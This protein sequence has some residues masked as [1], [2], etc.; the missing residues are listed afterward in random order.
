MR[1]DFPVHPFQ[2]MTEPIRRRIVEVLASGEHSY[3][4]IVEAISIEFSVTDAA[5][6]WH[7]AILLDNG[8]VITRDDYPYRFYRLDDHA[9]RWLRREVRHLEK[10]WRNRYGTPEG[11]G[12]PAPLVTGR[13]ARLKPGVAKGLRGHQRDDPWGPL[14]RRA[15]V[16]D[17]TAGS[18]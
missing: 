2:I 5:V 8:W 14:E 11:R 12:A 6:A 1:D 17:P 9:L 15:P 3:S 13:M 18:R 10:L 16:N 7:L 4:N